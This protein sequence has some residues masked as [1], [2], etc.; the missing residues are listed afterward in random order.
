MTVFSMERRVERKRGGGGGGGKKNCYVKGVGHVTR[1]R[2]SHW[3]SV[4]NGYKT[5]SHVTVSKRGGGGGRREE[6]GGGAS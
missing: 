5:I 2:A 1:A 4:I 3:T 6:G